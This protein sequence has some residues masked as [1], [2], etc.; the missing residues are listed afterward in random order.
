VTDESE[1]QAVREELAMLCGTFTPY[2]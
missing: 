1:I 2:P